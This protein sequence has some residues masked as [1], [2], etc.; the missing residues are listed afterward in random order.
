M[1]LAASFMLA[2]AFAGSLS[3]V[4]APAAAQT[5]VPFSDPSRPGTIRISVLNGS[6]AGTSRPG[7]ATCTLR[8]P[9]RDM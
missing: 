5:V 9:R 6:R 1:R 8:R 2:A 4:A 7:A 3:F